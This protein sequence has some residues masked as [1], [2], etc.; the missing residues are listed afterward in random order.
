M[1]FKKQSTP[2]N[3]PKNHSDSQTFIP[4]LQQRPL[5]PA[6][7]ETSVLLQPNPALPSEKSSQKRRAWRKISLNRIGDLAGNFVIEFRTI[8]IYGFDAG[9]DYFASGTYIFGIAEVAVTIR[10]KFL[11]SHCVMYI[12][13]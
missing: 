2:P 11:D 3:S 6:Q 5:R 4:H 8:F 13:L 12:L 7:L 9:L 1:H 10:N